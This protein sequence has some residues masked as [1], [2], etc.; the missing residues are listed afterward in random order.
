MPPTRL[1]LDPS[2]R[3]QQQQR[4]EQR[5]SE[6]EA[7]APLDLFDAAEPAGDGGLGL[8]VGWWQQS[9]PAM[10]LGGAGAG[11]PRVVYVRVSTD[12]AEVA[13]AGHHEKT[14]SWLLKEALAAVRRETV[15]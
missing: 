7:F 9:Q 4:G 11:L 1:R 12:E 8:A 2:R 15:A 10:A 13:V 6:E 14:L 3:S 5:Y